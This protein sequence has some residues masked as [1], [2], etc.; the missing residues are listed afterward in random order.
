MAKGPMVFLMMDDR[1]EEKEQ[2]GFTAAEDFTVAVPPRYALIEVPDNRIANLQWTDGSAG[3]ADTA[4]FDVLQPETGAWPEQTTIPYHARHFI[5]VGPRSGGT[6]DFGEAAVYGPYDITAMNFLDDPLLMRIKGVKGYHFDAL[7]STP[8]VNDANAK[9]LYENLSDDVTAW[10]ETDTKPFNIWSALP[11]S[12]ADSS[13]LILN[14][15]VVQESISLL[16]GSAVTLSDIRNS[17]LPWGFTVDMEY[18]PNTKD[19]SSFATDTKATLDPDD[20]YF[21][22]APRP[23]ARPVYPVLKPDTTLDSSSPFYDVNYLTCSFDST[24]PSRVAPSSFTT[25]STSRTTSLIRRASWYAIENYPKVNYPD[26]ANAPL[27]AWTRMYIMGERTF[28]GQAIPRVLQF[29]AI[30]PPVYMDDAVGDNIGLVHL[31]ARKWRDTNTSA[32]VTLTR[33]LNLEWPARLDEVLLPDMLI[34]LPSEPSVPQIIADYGFKNTV[35]N[36]DLGSQVR[37]RIISVSHR[38]QGGAYTQTVFGALFLGEYQPTAPV[39]DSK[40]VLLGRGNAR[41]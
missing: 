19:Y 8:N 20:L 17:L 21:R 39:T 31:L 37:V 25:K 4:T 23:R 13:D 2:Y 34:A 27:S 12:L 33:D 28:A 15:L 29:G 40:G 6:D 30:Y 38:W 18:E 1:V 35:S 3:V 26:A 16:V 22:F 9:R 14:N 11:R 36:D 41:Y 10:W 32:F 7:L 24:K 5:I